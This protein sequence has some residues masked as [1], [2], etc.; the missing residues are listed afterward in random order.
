MKNEILS[1]VARELESP[2]YAEEV[3]RFNRVAERMGLDEN[4]AERLRVPQR[5]MVVTFPYRHDD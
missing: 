4:V 5:A 2:L 1:G 3:S